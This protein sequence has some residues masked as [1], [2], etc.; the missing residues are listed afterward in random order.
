MSDL[1]FI[2]EAAKKL[3]LTE[4][5]LRGHVYRRSGAVPKPFKMGRKLAWR[6]AT[7]DTWLA[8]RERTAR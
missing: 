2:P 1:M 6:R 5:A 8:H 7:L 3:G 4:A